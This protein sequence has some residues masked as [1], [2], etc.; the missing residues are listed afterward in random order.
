MKNIPISSHGSLRPLLQKAGLTDK[1]A[2]IYLALLALHSGRVSS[3]AKTSGQSRSHTYLVLQSLEEKGLVSHVESGKVIQYV[4]EPPH[5]LVNYARD[6]E[7]EWGETEKLL[8]GAL[9][10]LETLTSSMVG[11]PRVTTLHGLDGMRQIYRDVL[12][13]KN[14]CS[15]FNPEMMF[16]TFGTNV[17]TQLFG[18]QILRGRELFVD[19]AGARRYLKEI[20]QRDDY[21]IR[22]L[23]KNM[24]FC[25]EMLIYGDTI[26]INA[27]DEQL[28]IVR[29]ENQNIADLFTAV[30]E[31]LWK[32]ATVTRKRQNTAAK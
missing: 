19:N 9:P 28:T 29:I 21:E 7:R 24:N 20:P 3:I 27:Y 13:Q 17:V 32:Q 6:R 26:A 14:F 30:F 4:A 31:G 15:F 12:L 11:Q 18:E 1:E 8:Q 23:P 22:L 25:T 10:L 16:N 5:R 2:E